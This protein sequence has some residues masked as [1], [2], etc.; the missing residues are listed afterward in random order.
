[1]YKDKA[2]IQTLQCSSLGDNMEETLA[3]KSVS[4]RHTGVQMEEVG[5]APHPWKI[6]K[7]C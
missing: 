1:M 2:V 4:L 7:Y 6:L 5:D 3:Y